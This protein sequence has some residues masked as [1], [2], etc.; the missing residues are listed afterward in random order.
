MNCNEVTSELEAYA[1]DAL[2]PETMRDIKKHMES[3]S[4]CRKALAQYDYITE[5]LALESAFSGVLVELPEGHRERFLSKLSERPQLRPG[6]LSARE[7][8]EERLP[9]T[10]EVRPKKLRRTGWWGVLAPAGFALSLFMLLGLGLFT[11]DLQTRL[12]RQQE[13]NR[14]IAARLE[15]QDLDLE[16]I[17][18]LNEQMV[19]QV[20]ALS[21]ERDS[22]KQEVSALQDSTARLQ[23][24]QQVSLLLSKPGATTRTAIN[25]RAG[26]TVLM[27]PA[28]KGLA[29]FAHSWPGLKEG[30]EYHLWLNHTTGALISGG[31]LKLLPLPGQDISQTFLSA[32]ET[33]DNYT[34]L[35]ITIEKAGVNT[36]NG[37]EIVRD[38]LI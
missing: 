33:M 16:N 31:S 12:E 29:L 38:K 26:I 18:K 11:L 13:Q 2:P 30:E 5:G 32:P 21:G 3:C 36:P 4:A 9:K 7:L 17:R 34:S 14:A 28:E 23:T 6:S 24:F 8:V 37:P 20:E 25:N 27:A 1:L 10:P 35:F 19:S 15:R 22:L